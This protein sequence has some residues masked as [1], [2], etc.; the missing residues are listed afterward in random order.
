MPAFR[1]R[2]WS[3][4]WRKFGVARFEAIGVDELIVPD[5]TLGG[6]EQKIATLARFITEV[7][8]RS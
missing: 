3:A 1:S 7:A 5:F 8:G 4:R 6:M 2:A